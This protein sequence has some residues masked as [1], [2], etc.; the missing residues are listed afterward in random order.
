M[1]DNTS[2][3]PLKRVRVAMVTAGKSY[4]RG[5]SPGFKKLENPVWRPKGEQ[6]I[7]FFLMLVLLRKTSFLTTSYGEWSGRI[8]S[9]K[10][11]EQINKD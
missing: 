1:V 3:E 4:T 10:Y 7:F 2:D 8:T 9:K 11:R 6:L 5:G